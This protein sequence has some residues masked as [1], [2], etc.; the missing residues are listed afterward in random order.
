MPDLPP[1]DAPETGEERS[2]RL[3]ARRART[4][5]D[6]VLSASAALVALCALGVSLYQTRLMREQQ[7]A[8]VW[9]RLDLPQ[10]TGGSTYGRMVRN[11]GLGP[12]LVRS[13]EVTVDGRPMHRWNDVATA[14]LADSADEIFRRDTALAAQ[15]N[16]VKR[17][18]VILPGA[19]VHHMRL[20]SR[21]VAPLFERAARRRLQTTICYCSLYGD[22]W[23]AREAA[24]DPAPVRA[25]PARA[26]TTREFR[27]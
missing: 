21:I 16:S 2:V 18:L 8:S 23:I 3:D 13:V 1:R 24:D 5:L 26:D 19:T 12:A 27:G 11:Q 14:L 4:V 9:P 10:T 7:R 25:C 22:C 15:H 20:E 17:G 6:W